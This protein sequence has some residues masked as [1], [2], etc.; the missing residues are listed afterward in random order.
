MGRTHFKKGVPCAGLLTI[1]RICAASGLPSAPPGEIQVNRLYNLI[2]TRHVAEGLMLTALTDTSKPSSIQREQFWAG[3]TYFPSP[4][5]GNWK[6]TASMAVFRRFLVDGNDGCGPAHLVC[7]IADCRLRELRPGQ[8]MSVSW[9]GCQSVWPEAIRNLSTSRQWCLV[10]HPCLCS[11]ATRSFN[12]YWAT[13]AR[14]LEPVQKTSTLTISP[15]E[16]RSPNT[17]AGRWQ[18]DAPPPA[19]FA[20][21][22]TLERSGLHALSFETC[23]GATCSF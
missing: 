9:G 15:K 1:S 2:A 21:Q 11:T 10:S 14:A 18:L 13:P 5:D 20:P 16:S 8:A 12:L 6:Q 3:A 22:P 19:T 17:S 7:D 23:R 4:S